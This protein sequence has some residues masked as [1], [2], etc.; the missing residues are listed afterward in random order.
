MTTV[1]LRRDDSRLALASLVFGALV[2]GLA[3]I[4]VRLAAC[5][6]AAAGFWRLA[7][8]TPLLALLAGARTGGVGTPSR[9]MVLA[10]IFFAFDLG[11]WHYGIHLTSVANATVLSNLTPIVV[12][13]LGW[14]V[15]KERP[16][17]L[18]V[19]GMAGAIAGAVVMAKAAAPS[20]PG[21]LPH[22]GDLLSTA[23]ALWY[24]LYF[25]AIR[26]ARQTHATTTVMLWSALAGAP[27]LLVAAL[28]LH[29]AI[30]PGTAL[31]WAAAAGLGM[32]HVFGQGAI[33]WALGRLPAATAA[34]TVLVQP[35]AAALLAY[36]IFGETL[37]WL[38]MMGAGLALLGIVVAQQGQ[39]QAPGSVP[40]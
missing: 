8:A 6:P 36:L 33:A 25:V 19:A 26:S 35:V 32:A 30:L 12:A 16:R 21:P 29:E 5:G 27:L 7:F 11:C 31:G 20:Q 10:G 15:F 13:L 14:W 23:T 37:T 17:P 2:I 38:Q 39:V 28:A 4:L 1:A 22:V 34:V 40:A 9:A 18:F 24:A 3:P